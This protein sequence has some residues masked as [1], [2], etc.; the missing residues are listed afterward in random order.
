M[1]TG[2]H[3]PDKTKEGGRNNR[4]LDNCKR[5]HLPEL[6]KTELFLSNCKTAFDYPERFLGGMFDW[7]MTESGL[8]K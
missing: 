1:M 4:L 8:S 6:H 2:E 3:E 5:Q 7:V